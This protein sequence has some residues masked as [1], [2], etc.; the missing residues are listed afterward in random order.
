MA[1]K[2]EPLTKALR[3]AQ[4]RGQDIVE[5]DFD[6]VGRLVGGL[7][8][9]ADL[10]QWWANG[11]QSQAL[12]WRAAG[13]HVDHV[14]LLRRRV[15]FARGETYHDRGR[16]PLAGVG[17]PQATPVERAPVGAP[18]DVR[19]RIQWCDAGTVVLDGQGKL[20][21][22]RLEQTAGLY[23]LTL[24]GSVTGRRPQI[25]VGETDNLRRRLAGNYRNP[26]P[27]QQTS[28]RINALLRA[29]LA[30]G[31]KVEVAVATAATVW[32]KDVEQPLSLAHKAGRLLG[33][34]AALVHEMAGAGADIVNLG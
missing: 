31:G 27:S 5:F 17:Q 34:N 2:Y 21:F 32:F 7:P 9:S 4:G 20:T 10:R 12:A 15:R 8:Q 26:G 6:D 1:G 33:E 14:W 11:S 25:Y 22:E 18:V 29:H 13:F 28:L 24:T 3:S 19:V 30:V 16:V 23:R